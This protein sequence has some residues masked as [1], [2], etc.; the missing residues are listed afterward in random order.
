MRS[1]R[2]VGERPLY[3]VG[4]SKADLLNFPDAVVRQCGLALSIAQH[5]GRTPSAK[6]WKG[7]GPGVLEA[8]IDHDSNTYR[9]VYV[10]RFAGAI[11]V[12]H[13]FQKKSPHGISTA[14]KDIALI[15]SRLLTAQLH[16]E[17]NH[18]EN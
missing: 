3:W 12:L 16:Y 17:K 13:C 14:R 10:V 9:A 1:M 7:A 6:A 11:Y 2:S 15:Q 5:G 18:D 4:K 8:I